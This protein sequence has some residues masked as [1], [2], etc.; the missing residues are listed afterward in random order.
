MGE[1]TKKRLSREEIAKLEIGHT[2]VSRGQQWALTV[3]FLALIVVYPLV[4]CCARQPFAEWRDAGT[5]QASIKAYET[6]IEDSSLLRQWL[7]APAQRFLTGVLDTGNEKAI[8]GADG[9]L[10]FSG[11]YDY[12]VNPGFL[13]PEVLHKRLLKG[14]QPDPARAILDFHRQL[15]DRGIR[16]LLLPVPVKPMLYADKLG[17]DPAPLQ[18]PSFVEFK[19]RMEADGIAVIDLVE[20]FAAMRADGREPYLK[21]DTHWTPLAMQLAAKKIAKAL[22]GDVASP[23]PET[24]PATN[25]GDIAA[26]LRLPH[27]ERYF[28]AET[29][30]VADYRCPPRRESEYLLL[31]DSFANIYSLKAMNWGENGGLA[32]ALGAYLGAPVDAILRNDAGAHATRQLLAQELKRGRDRLAGKKA[33]VYEFAIRE[34]ANGDWKM[35]DLTLGAAPETKLLAIAAP[36]TVTA[37]VLA[38]SPVPR[39]GS[40][41]YKDHVMSLHLGD[42]DGA[43]GVETLAYVVSMRDNVWTDA[44]RL[45]VGDVVKI[46]LEPWAAREAEFGSWNRSELDDENLLLAEPAFG[47]L[48]K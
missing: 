22:R 16:L 15:Q 32:E 25:L 29:V 3:F 28:P 14:A 36:R 5:L 23:A 1:P 42:I 31:G 4:Q 26:M 33:V 45:R 6:A 41:P 40:A 8:V 35:L 47:T 43:P 37:T 18:N 27:C 9:W 38:A 48:T 10:F 34:L 12:L 46:R 13:R 19:K 24:I 21:T 2:E 39:P 20:G 11:D 7:L 30:A 44:P 17:G